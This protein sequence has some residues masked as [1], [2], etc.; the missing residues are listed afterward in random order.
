MLCMLTLLFL[1]WHDQFAQKNSSAHLPLLLT[2]VAH[3]HGEE[4][5][6]LGD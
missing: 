2:A 1:C 5:R 3:V 4:K 6:L